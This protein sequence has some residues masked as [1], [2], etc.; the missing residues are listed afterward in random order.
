MTVTVAEK[1]KGRKHSGA[2]ASRK[3][4][5]DYIILNATSEI[6]AR[7]EL[8]AAVSSTLDG[9]VLDSA[10]VDEVYDGIFDGTVTW[11]TQT[12]KD[13]Q[14]EAQKEIDTATVVVNFDTT[15]GTTKLMRAFGEVS[16]GPP[17]EPFNGIAPESNL[18]IGLTDD[19]IEGVD[20]PAPALK[21]SET[22][23][24]AREEVTWAYVRFLH[25]TTGKVNDASFRGFDQ[26]EVRFLGA[27]AQPNGDDL[28]SFTFQ[29]S[30][31]PTVE[32]ITIGDITGIYKRGW[33]YLWT[34][35]ETTVDATAKKMTRKPIGVYVSEVS[36]S[37]DFSELGIGT[38]EITL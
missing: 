13:Q 19:G 6:E 38:E 18:A 2:L 21:W 3:I 1:P 17:D 16:Y 27:T 9:L 37:A 25:N 14:A 34:R 7:T 5:R 20:V 23:Q 8:A 35:Y 4:S 33:D 36:E 31:S 10:D 29:F 11:I 26:S 15:G 22:W 32:G 28:F 12:K 24:I 30:A